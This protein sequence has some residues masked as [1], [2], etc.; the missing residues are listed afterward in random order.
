MS[1]RPIMLPGRHVINAGL[2]LLILVLLALFVATESGLVFLL[3]T[4]LSFAIGFL[5]IIPIGGA[6]MPVVVSMLNSYSGW[7]AAGIG[8]TLKNPML[9]ITGA[10]VGSSGA[11]LSYIMCKAMNRSFVSVILGGFGETGAAAAEE[12]DKTYR[13]GSAEDAAFMMENAQKVIIVPGYGMAVAQAQHSVRELYDALTKKGVEVKFAI[14][15]VAGRMPGHMNVLL[16]EANIPYDVVHEMEDINS[17]FQQ[18]D[19][20]YVIGANDITNPA[21][22]TDTAS[23]IYGMPVLDVDR[24]KS[25][26]F[27]KRSMAAGYAGIDNPLFYMDRTMMLFGDAKKMTEEVVKSIGH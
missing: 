16:A 27:I 2:G 20:A 1:S 12:S 26:F 6:D 13:S 19:V 9:I 15:P 14:H 21:A 7:A 18:A 23:P 25:V 17:E 22:K 24:A 10:L 11:I 3:M 8:F 4:L 5:L